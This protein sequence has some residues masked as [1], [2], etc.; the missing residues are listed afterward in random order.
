MLHTHTPLSF[1]ETLYKSKGLSSFLEKSDEAGSW[2]QGVPG[3]GWEEG[4]CVNT[5][6]Q[7]LKHASR[8]ARLSV[9][10]SRSLEAHAVSKRFRVLGLTQQ[11]QKEVGRFFFYS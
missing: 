2:E 8:Y 9:S 5:L 11:A 10:T 6:E 4:L 3:G 1:R 7:N